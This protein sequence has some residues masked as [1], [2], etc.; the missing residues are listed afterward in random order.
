M[1]M[2]RPSGPT[3]VPPEFPGEM[4]KKTVIRRLF[5]TIPTTTN[6]MLRAA[7]IDRDEI[8][9]TTAR[10]TEPQGSR[11]DEL[12]NRLGVG[13]QQQQQDDDPLAGTTPIDHNE[14]DD[15]SGWLG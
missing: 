15:D 14:P 10:E 3:R 1:P 13:Q 8:I 7:E 2:I 6:L 11:T 5:K 12:K 4:A 9:D